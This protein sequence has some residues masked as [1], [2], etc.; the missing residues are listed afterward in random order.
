MYMHMMSW[1]SL[2]M[3]QIEL[4][5]PELFALGFRKNAEY[6]FV[7]TLIISENKE[8]SVEHWHPHAWL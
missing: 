4:E 8:P 5:H 7:Y 2:I 1:M 3:C 6:D